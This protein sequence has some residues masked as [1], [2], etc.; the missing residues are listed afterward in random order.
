MSG[1]RGPSIST[2]AIIWS[3]VL[4]VIVIVIIAVS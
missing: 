3:V 4:L 1:K 2:E